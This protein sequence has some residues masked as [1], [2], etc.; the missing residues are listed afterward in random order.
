[1][2]VADYRLAASRKSDLDRQE[3][4]DKTGVF[5]GA[6]AANPATNALLPVFVADY[7]LMGYGTGAIMAVPGQDT[8]DWDFAKSFRTADHPNRA[9]DRRPRRGQ[10]LHRR[11]P[12]DQ[13]QQLRG[14]AGRDGRRG[15]QGDR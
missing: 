10:R 8:R 4:R 2:P 9:A 15:R 5:T 11:G 6:Y 3:N 14:V 13:L 1:M 7:V 12:G